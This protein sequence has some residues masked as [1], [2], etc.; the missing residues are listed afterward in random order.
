MVAFTFL[1]SKIQN[2][3]IQYNKLILN[4]T[5]ERY[6]THFT[7]I[8]NVLF[9]YSSNEYLVAFNSQ[10]LTKNENDVN[11]LL[12]KKV[13][14][15]LQT[16]SFNPL[17]YLDNI[18]IYFNSNSFT[19]DKEGS[20]EA[21]GMFSN[22]YGS[23]KY[24]YMF[25]KEQFKLNQAFQ[26]LPSA[27]FYKTAERSKGYELIPFSFQTFNGNYQII[28]FIDISKTQQAFFGD[29]DNRQFMILGADNKIIYRSSDELSAAAMPAF[30][31]NQAYKL[32][33]GYYYFKQKDTDGLT[34]VTLVPYAN[35]ASE[36]RKMNLTLVLILIITTVIG[37]A[38]SFY[39]SKRI[40]S[41]VEQIIS[42]ITDRNPLKVKSSINEFAFIHQKIHSLLEER[43]G[44]KNELASKQSVLTSFNYINRLKSINSDLSE[45]KDF[46]ATED[47]FIVVLYELNFRSAAYEE[48][49]IQVERASYYIREHIDL[50]VSERFS[51]SHTFQIEKNQ[52][53][54]VISGDTPIDNIH[55]LLMELKHHLDQDKK[56]CIVTIAISSKFE[57]VSQFNNAY[58]QVLELVQRSR[59]VEE[60]QIVFQSRP[61]APTFAFSPGQDQELNVCLQAG[62][63]DRSLQLIVRCLDDMYQKEASVAQF[64][65]FADA[66]ISKVWKILEIFNVHTSASWELKP[67]MHRLKDCYTLNEYKLA[68][69]SVI[70][71][72]TSLVRS[73]KGDTDPIVTYVM[74]ILHTKYAEDISL[75]NL[76]DKL[77]MSNAYLSVYIKEKTGVNFIDHLNDIRINQAQALLSGTDMNIN[78]ISIQIGYRNITSF[79]RMF[80]KRTGMTPGEYRK[81]N[82]QITSL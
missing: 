28:A 61:L 46:I 6:S 41:P 17:F 48:L 70:E 51:D 74:D 72:A 64:R 73:K 53:L 49:Q 50:M 9:Q 16:D 32:Q 24:T 21:Q 55:S 3:I 44:V 25:W 62:D 68:F 59:L 78:D 45:W 77:N 35:I 33:K 43:D 22:L 18:V 57:H 39:H 13:I 42:S 54:S 30:E 20:S 4:N 52:I 14:Q 65:F 69:N 60:T 75:D 27:K 26:L 66:V 10:L 81:N 82:L 29:D 34:Y 8:K 11:Y 38:A 63:K 2:E 47:N 7:R 23:D 67:L 80:K 12:A 40:Q 37:L 71:S 5:V 79:N 76:A 1:K 31:T 56:Y 58:L 36:L 19:I 15:N